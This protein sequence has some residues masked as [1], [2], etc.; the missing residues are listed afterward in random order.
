[1]Q[2]KILLGAGHQQLEQKVAKYLLEGWELQGGVAVTGTWLYQA[3]IKR[4]SN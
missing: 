1:V 3:L 2:Y 4:L